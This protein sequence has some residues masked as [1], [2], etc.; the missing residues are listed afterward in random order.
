MHHLTLF[1]HFDL[2]SV[3]IFLSP[4][5]FFFCKSVVRISP[6]FIVFAFLA[7]VCAVSMLA[8]D[9]TSVIKFASITVCTSASVE[10]ET[11]V[12]LVALIPKLTIFP[13]FFT[14]PQIPCLLQY[15][16]PRPH[17]MPG[18]MKPEVNVIGI[19]IVPGISQGSCANY[20]I[21]LN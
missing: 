14:E 6:I 17:W 7:I 18:H 16:S 11:D 1:S 19:Y 2:F 10:M 9:A 5:R 13:M 15:H 8:T 3:S 4:V 20:M 12:F 21:I